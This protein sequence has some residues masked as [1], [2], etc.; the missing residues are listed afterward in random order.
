MNLEFGNYE[1]IVRRH[2]KAGDVGYSA[3][4]YPHCLFEAVDGQ[5]GSQFPGGLIIEVYVLSKKLRIWVN[6]DYQ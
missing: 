6:L 2:G 3:R 4:S 5:H 1:S